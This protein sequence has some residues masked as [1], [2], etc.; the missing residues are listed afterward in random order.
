MSD[1]SFVGPVPLL[2]TKRSK[3]AIKL[4]VYFSIIDEKRYFTVSYISHVKDYQTSFRWMISFQREI[5][6]VQV[7]CFTSSRSFV[8]V[9][10]N[11]IKVMTFDTRKTVH[12]Q[13]TCIS[14]GQTISIAHLYISVVGAFD[15]RNGETW[16][17]I[18]KLIKTWMNSILIQ[19]SLLQKELMVLY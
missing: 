7:I 16:I 18:L 5:S 2:S 1:S 11:R 6:S 13:K 17:W 14:D 15:K 4:P 9:K 10:V 12:W 19:V 8:R 3:K